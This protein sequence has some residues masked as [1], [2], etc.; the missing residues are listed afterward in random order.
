[1]LAYCS[2]G[3]QTTTSPLFATCLPAICIRHAVADVGLVSASC[4][5]APVQWLVAWIVQA[6]AISG[7]ECATAVKKCKSDC[8][9]QLTVLGSCRCW[10]EAGPAYCYSQMRVMAYANDA[11]P[12]DARNMTYLAINHQVLHVSKLVAGL[13]A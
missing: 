8:A 3:W 4:C 7:T 11:C 9:E 10:H 6:L 12:N 13:A 2:L 5:C 1:M